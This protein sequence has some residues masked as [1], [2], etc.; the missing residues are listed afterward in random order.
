[1]NTRASA[2]AN[3]Y[4]QKETC[5]IILTYKFESDEDTY[6]LLNHLKNFEEYDIEIFVVLCAS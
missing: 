1:M 6:R 4:D 3:K 5:K 2:R